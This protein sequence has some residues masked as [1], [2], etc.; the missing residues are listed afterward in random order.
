VIGHLEA[1]CRE[2]RVRIWHGHDYKSNLLGLL[3]RRRLG[4]HL[5]TTVHGWHPGRLRTRLYHA[6]DRSCLRRYDRVIAVSRN[7]FDECLRNGVPRARLRLVENAI[8]TEVFRRKAPP[9]PANGRRLVVGAIGRLAPEKGFQVLVRAMVQ[10]LQSGI[11]A[12][13]RIAGDGPERRAL[14]DEI[15]ESGHGDRI[16]MVGFQSDVMAFF[17]ECDVFVLSSI[18]EFAPNTLLEA[19]ALEVPVVATRTGEAEHVLDGGRCGVLCEPGSSEA[20][21]REIGRLLRSPELRAEL[22]RAARRRIEESFG[23]AQRMRRIVEIFDELP[24]G[25]Q[26]GDEES[27]PADEARRADARA[28]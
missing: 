23:F 8:D 10:L 15:R 21:A 12:E 18:V 11:D 4:L 25:P 17:A 16:R 22:A 1:I 24:L 3:L 19:M 28:L 2:H 13:L 6:I 27:A 5:V 14:E 7:L 9:R 20:L 26:P